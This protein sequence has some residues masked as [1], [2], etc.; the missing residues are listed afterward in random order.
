MN[1]DTPR[2]CPRCLAD[3]TGEP[4]PEEHRRYFGNAT[5]FSKVLGGYDRN[6]DR[7]T[8]WLCPECGHHWSRSQNSHKK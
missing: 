5:H 4:I 6:V 1:D 8:G 2:A 7:V 3:L